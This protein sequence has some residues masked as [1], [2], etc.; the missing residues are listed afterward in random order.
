MINLDDD[1][2][3]EVG[4]ADLPEV[5]RTPF[6]AQVN[7]TLEVR[8]GSRL[9]ERLTDEQLSQFDN[10]LKSGGKAAAKAIME[11][12][13]PNHS[14]VAAEEFRSLKSEILQSS[15]QILIASADLK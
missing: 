1:F 3:A 5:E 9:A 11:R 12:M 7:E 2:L 13:L 8:V 10:A 6:L 4:L 14:Q 15:R